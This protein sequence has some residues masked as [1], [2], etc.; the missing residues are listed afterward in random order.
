MLDV[1]SGDHNA[2]VK[3]EDKDGNIVF[4]GM[5]R[6]AEYLQR[7]GGQPDS[8]RNISTT[9]RSLRFRVSVL[10]TSRWARK[11]LIY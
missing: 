3:T 1:R 6:T 11:Q 5:S 2:L 7:I 10:K 9:Y 4:Y 8:K